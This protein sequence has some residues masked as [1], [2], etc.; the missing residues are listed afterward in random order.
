M[1]QPFSKQALSQQ[2][3]LTL[4][5]KTIYYINHLKGVALLFIKLIIKLMKSFLPSDCEL[6]AMELRKHFLS[7]N[8]RLFYQFNHYELLRN[9][10]HDFIVVKTVTLPLCI[11]CQH[12]LL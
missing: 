10:Q 6:K 11:C 8:V 9:F 2:I 4:G 1:A 5:L 3:I 7:K 12:L